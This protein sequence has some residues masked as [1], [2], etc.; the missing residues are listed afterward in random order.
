MEPKIGEKY[1]YK[2]ILEVSSL[3]EEPDGRVKVWFKKGTWQYA[4]EL[5]FF[6]EK[7]NEL[8]KEE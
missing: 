1:R 3:E 5:P 6:L 8:P 4:H 2:E 7:I